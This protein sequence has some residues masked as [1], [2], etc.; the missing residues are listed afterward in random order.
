MKEC[1]HVG[2]PLYVDSK[3]LK[4]LNEEFE[5]M[6]REMKGVPYMPG[7]IFHVYN[8]SQRGRYC[9]CDEHGETIHG[10]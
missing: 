10:E 4:P 8:G 2:I 7:R 9:I 6:Q 1:K 3:L 5:N